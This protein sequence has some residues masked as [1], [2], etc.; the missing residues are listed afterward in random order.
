LTYRQSRIFLFFFFCCRIF[1]LFFFSQLHALF[2]DFPIQ[3]CVYYYL[4]TSLDFLSFFYYYFWFLFFSFFKIIL[5]R[6][7]YIHA[8]CSCPSNFAFLHFAFFFS[9]YHITLHYI[10]HFFY[11]YNFFPSICIFL[12]VLPFS[13]PCSFFH[14][15]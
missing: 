6:H 8:H 15:K 7:V 1:L 4:S 9:L 3:W 11:I 14:P 10:Y 12:L 13:F 2:F 5:F